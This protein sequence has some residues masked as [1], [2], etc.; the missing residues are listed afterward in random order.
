MS[1][2]Q[3]NTQFAISTVSPETITTFNE[4]LVEIRKGLTQL[5]ELS[6]ITDFNNPDQ[7]N[8]YTQNVTYLKQFYSRAERLALDGL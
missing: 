1:E 6:K 8:F 3:N 7:K 5:R 2:E 4:A